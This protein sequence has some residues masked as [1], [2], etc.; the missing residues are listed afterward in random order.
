MTQPVLIL[1]IEL[2][3][4][5]PQVGKKEIRIVAEAARASRQ[6]KNIAFPYTFGDQGLP[7]LRAEYQH[8]RA[9]ISRPAP[10]T[11]NSRERS[12]QFF[13]IGSVIRADSRIACRKNAGFAAK[14]VDFESGV[15]CERRN[16][17]HRNA[18]DSSG[19]RCRSGMP[20]LQH[21]VLEK[22]RA[23]LLGGG[24]SHFSERVKLKRKVRQQRAE[25]QQL[26]GIT[27]CEN[28]RRAC[29]AMGHARADYAA[30]A[31]SWAACSRA[32]PAAARS[33]N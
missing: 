30:R 8:Q 33:S 9:P 6:A 1:W 19:R 3:R 11:R 22:G 26:A 2:R 31:S 24:Y 14:G 28:E 32:I 20:R 29:H 21:G 25:L 17:L 4:R 12:H 23:G 16:V 18:A 10:L 27:R 7:V 5:L 15:V 13:I